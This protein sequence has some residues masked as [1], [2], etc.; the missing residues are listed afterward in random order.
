MEIFQ[1]YY[2]PHAMRRI[3]QR[4]L[5]VGRSLNDV[6]C[7]G[8]SGERSCPRRVTPWPWIEHPTLGSNIQQLGGGHY[9][10]ANPRSYANCSDQGFKCFPTHKSWDRQPNS[11]YKF[12]SSQLIFLSFK[13]AHGRLFVAMQKQY[14]WNAYRGTAHQKLCQLVTVIQQR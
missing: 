1:S 14:W 6:F 13:A 5:A 8:G 10:W 2:W 12:W 3:F 11:F 4:Q 7:P 9:H